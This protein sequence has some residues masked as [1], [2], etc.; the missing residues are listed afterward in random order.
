MQQVLSGEQMDWVRRRVAALKREGRV[1]QTGQDVASHNFVAAVLL[2]S[3]K[4]FPNAQRFRIEGFRSVHLKGGTDGMRTREEVFVNGSLE[5]KIHCVEFE[6]LPVHAEI[7][8]L[9]RITTAIG[10]LMLFVGLMRADGAAI[11]RDPVRFSMCLKVGAE[12]KL[13]MEVCFHSGHVTG[14]TLY[15]TTLVG[16]RCIYCGVVD[17]VSAG[18]MVKSGGKATTKWNAMKYCRG[19]LDVFARRV[20]YCSMECQSNGWD[21]H[22]MV[23]G[24]TNE[25][26]RCKKNCAGGGEELPDAIDLLRSLMVDSD[27]MTRRFEKAVEEEMRA[28]NTRTPFGIVGTH[29]MILMNVVGGD[30]RSLV[31][32]IPWLA[33]ASVLSFTKRG[34]IYL[35]V[36]QTL[37]AANV[38]LF[39]RVLRGSHVPVEVFSDGSKSLDLFMR[40]EPLGGVEP[41]GRTDLILTVVVEEAC[42]VCGAVSRGRMAGISFLKCRKCMESADLPPVLYC[43][44]ECME[45]NRANHAMVCGGKLRR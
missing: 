25:L 36:F 6:E 11:G 35:A 18:E 27:E 19:C 37:L 29:I 38:R 41:V 40:C 34:D 33:G 2:M 43:S 13:R 4:I 3:P 16:M 28:L 20:P 22:R 15:M 8:K 17:C 7:Y 39:V 12:G 1:E 23:C 21:I 42:L 32:E 44:H 31:D 45:Q 5:S 26:G 10:E 14:M 9:Y 30:T 24:G